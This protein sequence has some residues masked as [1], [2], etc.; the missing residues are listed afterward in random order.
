MT[1]CKPWLG[2]LHAL[3]AR[4]PEYGTQADLPLLTLVE[5]QGLFVF[6][7]HFAAGVTHA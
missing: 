3:A 6:L 2:R 7:S 5:F 1:H 4:F